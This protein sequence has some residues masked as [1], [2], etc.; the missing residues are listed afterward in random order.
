MDHRNTQRYMNKLGYDWTRD[1]WHC[2][3][4]FLDTGRYIFG[5]H[6]LC[7]CY[8][9]SS[10]RTLVDNLVDF[11]NTLESRS[12]LLGHLQLYIDCLLHKVMARTGF[13]GY[14]EEP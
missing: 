2:A 8:I 13:L 6:M 3:H 9:Q 12:I 14:A 11:P 10:R 1:T 7:L 5:E 4:I